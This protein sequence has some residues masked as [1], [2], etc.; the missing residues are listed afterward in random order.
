MLL[1]HKIVLGAC[2]ALIALGATLTALGEYGRYQSGIRLAEAS[3][4]NDANLWRQ[5]VRTQLTQI[6]VNTQALS[7]NRNALAALRDGNTQAVQEE[8]QP[9]YNR[10]TASGVVDRIRIIDTAGR[11]VFAEPKLTG[12]DIQPM[13]RAALDTAEV[14][15]GIIRDGTDVAIGVAFPLYAGGKLAGAGLLAQKLSITAAQMKEA[16]EAEVFVLTPE[17]TIVAATQETLPAGIEKDGFVDGAL[18]FDYVPSG[19]V[20]FAVTGIPVTDPAGTVI[21]RTITVK[22]RTAGYLAQQQIA[23]LSYAVVLGVGAL[24]VGGL[25]VYLRWS[26]NPLRGIINSISALARGQLDLTIVGQHRTD[27]IGE[28]AGALVVFQQASVEREQMVRQEEARKAEQLERAQK[29]EAKIARFQDRV[30]AAMQVVTGAVGEMRNAMQVIDESL[31]SNTASVQ[32]MDQAID[33]ASG[34]VRSVAAASEEL[35]ASSNEIARQVS[36]S[37]TISRSAVDRASDAAEKVNSL[38]ESSQKIGEVLSLISGI[39]GQT[40]LLALN[41]TIEAARAGDAG[42]GFAVVASE[43]KALATQTERATEDI[44]AQIAGIQAATE[45]AVRSIDQITS[46]VGAMDGVAST[47]AAAVEEQNAATGEIT[48][49]ASHAAEGTSEVHQ[50]IS[51][52]GSGAEKC[53]QLAETGMSATESLQAEADNLREEI[54]A[55]L[56]DVR[57]A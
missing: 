51:M 30:G 22:D 48:R 8:M 10:L 6:Q 1:R 56:A 21:A 19:E 43:V 34:A 46:S 57:A 17:G 15:T 47:I 16:A 3:V 54:E 53:A 37:T 36:E 26:M 35:A 49:S 52:I 7:R 32:A 25:F 31:K 14:K 11:P 13:F 27:E 39:A 5:I 41:A 24:A 42:K 12:P 2:C 4:E 33:R 50:S 23:Y 18:N 20:V 29:I 44:A 38:V 45:A 40:N 9:T 28:I 55:F